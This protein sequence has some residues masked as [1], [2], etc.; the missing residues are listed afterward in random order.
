MYIKLFALTTFCLMQF[1]LQA[2]NNFDKYGKYIYEL[3]LSGN[4]ELVYEFVDLNEYTS[5]IDRLEKLPT[6]IKEEI[7]FD[8]TRSYTEVRKGFESECY[9]ILDLYQNSQKNGTTFKYSVTEFKASKN[10]PDIGFITCYYIVN[11]PDGEEPEE[12]A[13]RF[14]CIY[15]TNGW[16]ILDGFFNDPNL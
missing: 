5:Y 13:I 10:F 7:K 16:R 1:A 9:R 6:E 15:T 14:E 8:A 11:L 3:V 4:R 2:Q 12:D